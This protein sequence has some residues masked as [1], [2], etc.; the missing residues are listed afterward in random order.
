MCGNANR[1]PQ[2]FS[3]MKNGKI[4]NYQVYPSLLT[5]VLLN[6]GVPCFANSVDPYQ[7]AS[8]EAKLSGAA[9][10]AIKYVNL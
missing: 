3:R 8:E 9:L 2:K 5:L 4:T 10:F 1:K 7:L 6:P